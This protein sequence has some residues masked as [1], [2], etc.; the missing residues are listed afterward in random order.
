MKKKNDRNAEKKETIM[1]K[2]N[3]QK[4]KIQ[5]NKERWMSIRV[6]SLKHLTVTKTRTYKRIKKEAT[7]MN[8]SVP[9]PNPDPHKLEKKKKKKKSE[10]K[11]FHH[12]SA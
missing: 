5:S 4:K 1:E 3:S 2:K 6:T 11:T 12:N 8:K 7:D 10:F 9:P